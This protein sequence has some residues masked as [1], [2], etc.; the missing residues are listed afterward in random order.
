MRDIDYRSRIRD[1]SRSPDYNP[2]LG[3]RKL[4]IRRQILIRL[5]L[6]ALASRRAEMKIFRKL[7]RRV[8]RSAHILR[9]E[10]HQLL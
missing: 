5:D 10:V 3:L 4:S 1:R 7:H 9:I 8:S 6:S 2:V